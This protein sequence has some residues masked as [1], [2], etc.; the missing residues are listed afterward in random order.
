[1]TCVNKQILWKG[2]KTASKFLHL[3][4]TSE[5]WEYNGAVYQLLL[6]PGFVNV[7][8]GL[9]SENVHIT[10][11]KAEAILLVTSKHA[12]LKVNTEKNKYKV[13]PLNRTT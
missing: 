9:L 12:G 13:C 7:E 8:V 5:K 1:M 3:T 2:N 4:H 6:T 10:N 11:K